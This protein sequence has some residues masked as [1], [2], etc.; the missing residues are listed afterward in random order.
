M[1]RMNQG[2]RID[3]AY[4]IKLKKGKEKNETIKAL[5]QIHSIEN[6]SL[7]LQETTVEL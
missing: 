6:I 7:M 2:K 4:Q 1:L 5:S 3:Y